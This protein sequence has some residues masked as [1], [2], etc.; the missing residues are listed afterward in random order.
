MKVPPLKSA[1]Q[2]QTAHGSAC[3]LLAAL[4]S[5]SCV[6]ATSAAPL[7]FSCSPDNDLFRVASKNGMALKRFDTPA[8]AVEAAGEGAGVL[9][10]ADGYPA[11][12]TTLDAALFDKAARKKLRLYVEYPSYL[13]GVAV[14]TP[15]GTHWE[16]AVIA[17]D[18]FAPALGKLR[19]LAIHGCRF[20]PV[21]AMHPHIVI[22]RVAG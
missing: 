18:V 8:A 9:L 21:N 5:L 10:L 3:F 17:S 1:R 11:R 15:R 19:I 12:T 14:G 16:R 13:P 22:G 6:L 20:V 2:K 4:A 7:V